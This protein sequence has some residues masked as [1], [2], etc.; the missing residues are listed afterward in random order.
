M[1][2]RLLAQALPGARIHAVSGVV[3]YRSSSGKNN[4]NGQ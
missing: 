1:S 3:C 4:R 2:A